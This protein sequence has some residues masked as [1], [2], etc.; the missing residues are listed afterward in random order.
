MGAYSEN[1]VRTEMTVCVCTQLVVRVDYCL[2]CVVHS[3]TARC[4]GD[5][6]LPSCLA[7]QY[8][9]AARVASEIKAVNSSVDSERDGL[10]EAESRLAT[11]NEQLSSIRQE[12]GGVGDELGVMEREEG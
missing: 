9:E 6:S 5:Q 1:A 2:W 8:K 10:R 4:Q 7:R 12:L 11:V 3:T